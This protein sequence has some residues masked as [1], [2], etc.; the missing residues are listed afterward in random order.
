MIG[1]T[2]RVIATR[3]VAVVAV[4][5]ERCELVQVSF[6]LDS[7]S[8]DQPASYGQMELKRQRISA[9]RLQPVDCD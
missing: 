3:E 6:E 8:Q 7:F 5:R 2:E 1:S 9:Y 4:E